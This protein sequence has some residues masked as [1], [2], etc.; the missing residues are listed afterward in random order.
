MTEHHV[1]VEN[2]NL[3]GLALPGEI[4]SLQIGDGQYGYCTLF[5]PSD[6]L[7]RHALWD[8]VQRYIGRWESD[9]SAPPLTIRAY[10]R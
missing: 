5:E 4:A 6:E 10:G 1:Q 3:A 8:A 9:P 2:R 7:A